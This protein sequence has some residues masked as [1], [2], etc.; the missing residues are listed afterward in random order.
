MRKQKKEFVSE[1]EEQKAERWAKQSKHAKTFARLAGIDLK[2]VKS[3]REH[4]EHMQ[5][6]ARTGY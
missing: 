5:R 6:L 4:A 1:T 2:K 3:E